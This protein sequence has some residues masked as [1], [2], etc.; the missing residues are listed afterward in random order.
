[1]LLFLL[2]IVVFSI[3]SVQT[4]LGTYATTKVNKTYGT[5]IRIE[6]AG[7]RFNGD[8]ALKN[9][10][11][12]DHHEET[13]IS[14]A[15]LN[16]SIISFAKIAENKLTFG[17]IDLFGFYFNIKKYSGEN[18]TNLDIFVDKFDRDNQRTKTSD[19][20]LSSSTVTVHTSNFSYVDENLNTP[21]ILDLHQLDLAASDFLISGKDIT[22]AITRL[23]FED[24]RGAKLKNLQT[25]FSYSLTQMK[26]DRLN[27]NSEKSVLSGHL[28]FDYDRIDFE[29]FLNKVKV[30]GFFKDSHIDLEDLNVFY[31]EFGTRQKAVLNTVFSGTLNN[32]LVEEF[33]L[34]M[35]NNT[36]VK[37]KIRFRNL[38]NAG[39]SN[40]FEMDGDFQKIESTYTGL[41]ALLP[42]VLGARIPSGL[43]ALGR[44]NM[45]GSAKVS[46]ETVKTIMTISTDI[47]M[48]FAD[49]N[50]EAITNKET[51]SYKGQVQLTDFDF[52]PT[53]R[54]SQLFLYHTT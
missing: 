5:D 23:N 8:V 14:V 48:L 1:M 26:F 49:L 51:T 37:G 28:Q 7:L 11:I 4:R 32:L 15:E 3:P 36:A 12:K 18:D 43:E 22:A 35:R 33:D 27:I 45:Q 39:S 50:L 31:N 52:D 30:S 40:T 29:D 9:I 41:S 21:L 20:L 38:F 16:T 53:A 6:K 44:F 46:N 10:L 54:H 17:A 47:G 42:R 13:L 25:N 24:S 2:S 34:K 19:F